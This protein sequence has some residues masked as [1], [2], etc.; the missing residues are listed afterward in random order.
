MHDSMLVADF[1]N[2]CEDTNTQIFNLY[3]KNSVLSH[4]TANELFSS[5]YYSDEWLLRI[6]ESWY[7]N[8]KEIEIFVK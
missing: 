6:V 5:E 8:G 2:L 4:V 3:S 7:R 1:L